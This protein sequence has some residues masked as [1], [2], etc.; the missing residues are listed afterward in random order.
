MARVQWW[1][2]QRYW[3]PSRALFDQC[4]RFTEYSITVFSVPKQQAELLHGAWQCD[5]CGASANGS[6]SPLL[7]MV[8]SA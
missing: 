8:P 7:R 1:G 4:R 5:R 6:V 3:I 2:A